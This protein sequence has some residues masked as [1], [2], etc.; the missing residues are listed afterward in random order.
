MRRF[1]HP[2]SSPALGRVV[3]LWVYGHYGQPIVVFPSASGMGDEWAA[4]GMI[5]V[6]ADLLERGRIKLYCV[7][8]NV[9]EAWTRSEGDPAWRIGRHLAYERFVLDT[10]IPA[11]WADCGGPLPLAATGCSLGAFYAANLALKQPELCRWALC[12]SGRYEMRAFT[13]GFDSLEVYFNNPLA[14]VA[15][16]HGEALARVREQTSLTLV[17]GQGA[18]EEGCKEETAAL[19]G[20]LAAKGIPHELDLWGTDAAH[21]WEWWQR[22]ASHH[23]HRR[24]AA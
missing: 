8:S 15:N 4:R 2:L 3:D 22:Q 17:C 24:F 9:G 21:D 5:H 6:L 11:I 12:L 14:Y 19:A 18:W 10:L 7:E 16:L 13:G 20:L 23:L 1:Q